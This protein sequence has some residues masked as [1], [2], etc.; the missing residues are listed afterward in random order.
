MPQQQRKENPKTLRDQTK[1]LEETRAALLN[2]LEDTEE[3]KR[4]VEVSKKRTE[5]IIKNLSDGLLVFDAQGTLELM[6]PY[7]EHIFKTEQEAVLQ[8]VLGELATLP[9]FKELADLL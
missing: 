3:A 1:E 5:L 8:K 2:M 4:E 6:N 9:L 7:A